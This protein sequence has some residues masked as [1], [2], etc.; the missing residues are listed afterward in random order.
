MWDLTGPVTH[1]C[2]GYRTV[3]WLFVSIVFRSF[4]YCTMASC[5]LVCDEMTVRCVCELTM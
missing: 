3:P 4:I 1:N 5:L 2:A